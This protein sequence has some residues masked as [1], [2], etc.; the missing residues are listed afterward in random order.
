MRR[1]IIVDIAENYLYTFLLGLSVRD[2]PRQIKQSRFAESRAIVTLLRLVKVSP[3]RI[4][5]EV[6]P[7][8]QTLAHLLSQVVLKCIHR[9]HRV[10]TLL[11]VA[12]SRWLVAID[13]VRV[14]KA[15]L[16]TALL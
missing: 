8:D 6:L 2:V 16:A 14:F 9:D 11:I 1:L 5:L 10:E 3:K 15:A 12:H 13:R 7:V 4:R